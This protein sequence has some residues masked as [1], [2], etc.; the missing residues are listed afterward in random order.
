MTIYILSIH[1]T[2]IL[3]FA[4]KITSIRWYTIRSSGRHKSIIDERHFP[5][6]RSPK[7]S[8]RFVLTIAKLDSCWCVMLSANQVR[9]LWTGTRWMWRVC[10][11]WH[12]SLILS[13]HCSGA[14]LFEIRFPWTRREGR[15]NGWI[16]IVR[17]AWEGHG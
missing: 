10:L 11:S 7:N 5:F 14:F 1:F 8:S 12:T 13:S 2:W 4:L 16:A 6:C 17:K 3:K 9:V 15:T